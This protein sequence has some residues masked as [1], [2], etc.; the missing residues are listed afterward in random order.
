LPPNLTSEILFGVPESERVSKFDELIEVYKSDFE[1]LQAK[2]KT[3]LEGA[4]KVKK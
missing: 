1:E 2:A 3:C 4:Q